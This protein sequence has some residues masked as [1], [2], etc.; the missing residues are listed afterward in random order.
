VLPA[1]AAS[2]CSSSCSK[3]F[4]QHDGLTHA[5]AASPHRIFRAIEWTL[6]RMLLIPKGYSEYI[7][8][9]YV[10]AGVVREQ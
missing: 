5:I 4:G 6:F 7:F 9:F 10:V 3:F 2:L 8:L 1:A